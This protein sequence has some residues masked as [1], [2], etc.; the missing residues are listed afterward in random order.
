MRAAGTLRR[1][2]GG[3]IWACV[4][5]NAPICGK[6]NQDKTPGVGLAVTSGNRVGLGVIVEGDGRNDVLIVPARIDLDAG[7]A[8]AHGRQYLM[9]ASAGVLDARTRNKTMIASMISSS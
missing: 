6:A 4:Q 1:C 9:P 8:F 2:M 7:P 3:K 5:G